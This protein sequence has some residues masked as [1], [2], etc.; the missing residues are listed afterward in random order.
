[1]KNA[2]Q[3]ANQLDSK[4]RAFAYCDEVVPMMEELRTAADKLEPL[5]DD[6]MWPLVKYRE[7]LFIR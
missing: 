7:M 6:E 2:R 1:M 3:N 5:V 4:Q